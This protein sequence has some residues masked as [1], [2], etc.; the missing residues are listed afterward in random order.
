MG[1]WMLALLLTTAPASPRAPAFELVALGVLGGDT[2]TNLSSVLLGLPGRPAELMIDGGSVLPGLQ[3]AL[4]K[5]GRLA[6]DASPSV[7][8]REALTV[9][10][11]LRAFLLTHAHLDH[12]VGFG[13]SSTLQLGL[14]LQ[15]KPPL[16]MV[17]LPP[18]LD[19]LSTHVFHAP[20]WADFTAAP[21]ASPALVL[22]PLSPGKAMTLGSFT[23]ETIELEHTVPSAAFLIHA[24]EATY[25]HLG[26]TGPTTQV[27]EV[28][29]PLLSSGSL[30]AV[31]LELSFPEAQQPLALT[32][33]H[34]TRNLFLL[35][36]A[37]LAGLA[38]PLPPASMDPA[39]AVA[40][41]R[42][43]APHFRTCP[44]LVVHI[45]AQGYDQVRA[46]LAPLQAAGLNLIVPEQGETYRF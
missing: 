17:G 26:D 40:L 16:P 4:E 25:L 24:G 36:L 11:P 37:K 32:S 1:T 19:A 6:R 34:L 31:A 7:Q 44:V 41:A 42:A 28:A 33:R 13:V 9:L 2:D 43:L 45:K 18:T 38:G 8:I 10:K 22:A 12:W 27:W 30:R 29:R 21:K 20:L 35:E 5:R 23:V 39:Q 3:R 14:A 46:E 15:G